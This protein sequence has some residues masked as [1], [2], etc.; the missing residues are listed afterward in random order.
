MGK[1]FNADL[2]VT[3]VKDIEKQKGKEH[4]L[5]STVKKEDKEYGATLSVEDFVHAAVVGQTGSGKST[6]LINFALFQ[7]LLNKDRGGTWFFADGKSGGDFESLKSLSPLPVANSLAELENIID[8]VWAE[9]Q[10]R[11]TLFKKAREEGKAVR[12]IFEYREQ[13]GPI[14]RVWVVIDELRAFLRDLDFD[15]LVKE[16]GSLPYKLT[17]LLA[18]SRSFGF[19][20]IFASQRFQQDSFPVVIR[21]NLPTVYVHKVHKND[22]AILEIEMPEDLGRGEY[23]V[24]TE[25]VPP[26][27]GY[28]PVIALK[29]SEA[30][31][32]IEQHDLK[33]T[34][35]NS[36]KEEKLS[37]WARFK[38]FLKGLFQ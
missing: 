8:V 13:V 23:I 21:C 2:D 7:S 38:K 6:T 5:L 36:S 14:P 27:R 28:Y 26:F 37:L 1:K 18:E 16:P 22:Q 30:K 3:E 17:R 33:Y 31:S 25:G 15:G 29:A 19:T 9:Y 34:P 24:K 12:N 35:L 20:F 11:Q 4:I 32:F 10:H